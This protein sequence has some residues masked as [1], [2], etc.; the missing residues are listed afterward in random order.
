MLYTTFSVLRSVGQTE[1]YS[2]VEMEMKH[3]SPTADQEKQISGNNN[4]LYNQIEDVEGW[5]QFHSMQIDS[6]AKW[7]N[8]HYIT[9]NYITTG[10]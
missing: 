7:E 2:E 5:K 9:N 10:L 4:P 6:I 1:Q 3:E 8:P